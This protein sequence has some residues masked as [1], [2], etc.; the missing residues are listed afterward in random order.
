MEKPPGC[1]A[2]DAKRIQAA[3]QA[4]GQP[5]VL[6]FM[7]RFASGYRVARNL[8]RDDKFGPLLGLYGQYMTAPTYFSGDPDY[9][10]FY[11]HHCVH[12]MD[13]L[14][15][16]VGPVTA[17]Q[18]RKVEAAA[19]KLLLH[20]AV[21]FSNGAIG[22][23]IMGTVQARTT[24][25]EFIQL[26]GDQQ[27]IEINNIVNV[28]YYRAPAFKSSELRATLHEQQDTLTWQPNWTVAADEDHKGYHALLG[29]FVALLQGQACDP[30][31]PTIADGVAAMQLLDTLVEAIENV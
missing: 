31:T 20:V 12:Y 6:G 1:N 19:G 25:M 5:V 17:L 8:L 26:M 24:P 9:S 14:H 10:G 28:H 4:S 23:L 18:V 22:T 15:Y 3:S 16:L 2:A 13:M 30:D 7:K 27:R 11:L 29:Q 21:E